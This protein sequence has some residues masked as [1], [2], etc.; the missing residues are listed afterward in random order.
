LWLLELLKLLL[1]KLLLLELLLGLLLLEV[2]ES[3]SS[4][5]SWYFLKPSSLLLQLKLSSC[6]LLSLPLQLLSPPLCLCSLFSLLLPL[7]FSADN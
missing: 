5:I 2:A 1:L 4:L 7:E 3:V 6:L